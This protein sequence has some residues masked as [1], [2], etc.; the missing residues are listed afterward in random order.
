MLD[1][2][3]GVLAGGAYLSMPLRMRLSLALFFTIVRVNRWVRYWKGRSV[4]SRLEW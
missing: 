4:E 2:V 1:S 3:T